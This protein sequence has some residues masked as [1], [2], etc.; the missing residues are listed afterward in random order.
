MFFAEVPGEVLGLNCLV[1]VWVLWYLW[2]LSLLPVPPLW[3]VCVVC[4]GVLKCLL[5]VLFPLPVT[6]R[7]V[8]AAG[9]AIVEVMVQLL[10]MCWQA[11]NGGAASAWAGAARFR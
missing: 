2:A 1:P 4:V 8:S 11:G 5:R 9:P 3:L 10:A 7:P 6:V